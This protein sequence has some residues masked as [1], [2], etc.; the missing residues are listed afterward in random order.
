MF[1]SACFSLLTISFVR[2]QPCLV[3]FPIESFMR[4]STSVVQSVLISAAFS[5]ILRLM[6]YGF[7]LMTLF[8]SFTFLAATRV[9]ILHQPAS[10]CSI[11]FATPI[12]ACIIVR[13]ALLLTTSAFLMIFSSC[14]PEVTSSPYR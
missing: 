11:S 13:R 7:L 4:C 10:I 1:R 14:F 2:P 12:G 6:D 5:S 8:A 3:R 9:S